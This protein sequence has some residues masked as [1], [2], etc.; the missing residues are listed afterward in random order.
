MLQLGS[1]DDPHISRDFDLM[2]INLQ[3]LADAAAKQRPPISMYVYNNS[4]LSERLF[5]VLYWHTEPMKC[6]HGELMCREDVFY[7]LL[8]LNAIIV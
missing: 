7:L 5:L 2:V 8:I 3:T 1:S 6:G 4:C